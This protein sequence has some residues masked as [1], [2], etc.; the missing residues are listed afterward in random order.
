MDQSDDQLMSILTCMT[1]TDGVIMRE[2][3][4]ERNILKK[5]PIELLCNWS[6]MDV[7]E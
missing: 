1:L 7:T 5:S 3:Q 6:R 2:C 4:M